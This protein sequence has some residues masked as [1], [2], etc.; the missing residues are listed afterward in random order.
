MSTSI[1]DDVSYWLLKSLSHSRNKMTNEQISKRAAKNSYDPYK[2]GLFLDYIGKHLAYK[3]K[4]ILDV[5]CGTGNLGILLAK[6]GATRVVGID[7]DEER[8]QTA[9][10]L[11]KEYGVADRV[12]FEAIDFNEYEPRELFDLAFN[13]DA[14][15]HVLNPLTSLRKIHSCLVCG[16]LL[17]TIFGPL[18]YSPYGAHMW[19]FTKVPWVHFLFAEKTVLRVRA[20]VFRPDENIIKY[21]DIRGHLNR[22]SITK[23]RKLVFEAGFTIQATRVNPPQDLGKY[24]IP[25]MLVNSVPFFQELGALQFLA[26]LKKP[27]Q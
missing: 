12:E 22:M 9:R 7:I 11:A 21:E 2:A 25:N 4:T 23:F 27:Q 10:R 20:E 24:K 26:V 3:G 8:V 5:G 17:G 6:S 19:G 13:E 16:G 18:W 14:F 1:W 15:E